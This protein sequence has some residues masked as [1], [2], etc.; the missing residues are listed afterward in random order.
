MLTSY[1]TDRL[2]AE[3]LKHCYDTAPPRVQQYLRAEIDFVR[4]KINPGDIVLDMGCGY[5]RAIPP[6]ARKAGRVVGIDIS[7]SSLR[8][9]NPSLQNI[10][11]CLLVAM[12][13]S[14]MALIKEAFDAVIC[15]QNGIS[16]FHID[17]LRLIEEGLR[18]VKE[19]GRFFISTYSEKFWEVRLNWFQLQAAE[20]LVGEI[21]WEKTSN[22]VIVCRDGFRATTFSEKQFRDLA[23]QCPVSF[24]ITEVDQSSLFC[25]M[26]KKSVS[27]ERTVSGVE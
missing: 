14:R 4:D 25:V 1:Y 8:F 18:V 9:G 12:D 21:D 2:A 26:I 3:R 11:N 19:N 23:S 15:L 10:D 22:G 27:S 20:G 6:L 7:L 13:A 5:G 17:P 16:A 24:K